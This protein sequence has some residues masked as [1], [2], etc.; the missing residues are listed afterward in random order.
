MRHLLGEWAKLK[1]RFRDTHKILLLLDYDGTLS[2]ITPRPDKAFIDRKIKKILTLLSKKNDVSIGI[3]SG[4]ALTKIQKLVGIKNIYYV[5]NHGFEIKGP[6]VKYTHPAYQQFKPNIKR[7]KKLLNKEL[8]SIKGVIIEDKK[9]TV[10]VHHRLIKR[11]DLKRLTEIFKRTCAPFVSDRKIKLSCGKKS[12]EIRPPVK[13]DKG[14]AVK[15]ILHKFPKK[16]IL[17][18]YLGDDVTDE[19][20]FRVLK[21]KGLSV[22]I[23]NPFKKSN[24]K[25]YLK[26]V[27]EVRLFLKKLVDWRYSYECC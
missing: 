21:K 9:L 22:F 20:A 16:D 24:A 26:S 5:G 4:R 18:I 19:D 2:S 12:W 1:K 7:I 15:K 8:S 3:V 14:E 27:S 11:K 25:Y 17:P 23:G 6:T 10:T 13:W